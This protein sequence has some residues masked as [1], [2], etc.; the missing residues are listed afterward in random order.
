M[1]R[2]SMR[3]F[4]TRRLNLLIDE[5]LLLFASVSAES[6]DQVSD[7]LASLI[8]ARHHIQTSR[9]LV[10]PT[11]YMRYRT[12]LV[13]WFMNTS[14]N[15]PRVFRLTM[16]MSLP[17]FHA[18]L[19]L[20]ST[21][22]VFQTAHRRPQ[23]PIELQLAVFLYRMG[24]ANA[25]S[26]LAHT[27]LALGLSEG[28]VHN[29]TLR[30]I[31]AI[32]EVKTSWINWL[33]KD[34][35]IEHAE[36]V[37]EDSDEIFEGCVG[38]IDGTF[39]NLQFTPEV[40]DYYFYFNRKKTYAINVMA[41][42]TDGR[43]ITFLRVGDTSAV[44]DVRVFS[45]S[46][47]HQQP[48]DFFEPNE[49]LIGDSAYSASIHMIPPFKG[50]RIRGAQG[51]A[52][53]KFNFILSQR[54]IA[55]EHTFGM[56]KAQFPALTNL[57]VRIRGL[58]SHALVVRWFEAGCVLHN[59]LTARKD[60]MKWRDETDWIRILEE[61]EQDRLDMEESER[62]R[63]AIAPENEALREQI[64]RKVIQTQM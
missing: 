7:D 12:P 38:Y 11:T 53:R 48:G 13:N 37:S 60:E 56:I 58:D 9:Y 30:V 31:E 33:P 14:S 39:V 25:G 52:C 6:F 26:S 44:H 49:Y 51:R 42:C 4:F 43:Q 10:R 55:I 63:R 17:S 62:E 54:R 59:F 21:H 45:R 36:R 32:Q 1:P 15:T 28:S 8:V 18:F 2:P 50:A 19:T 3:Q 29:Y 41:V 61:M 40:D 57:P 34:A 16:R 35:R 47:L 5:Q 22:S 64:L 23:A 20:I 24:M 46:L 27:A